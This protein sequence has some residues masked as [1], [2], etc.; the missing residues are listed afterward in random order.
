MKAVFPGIDT[1]CRTRRCAANLFAMALALISA[2]AQPAP[3]RPQ[4]NPPTVIQLAESAKFKD[5]R[6]AVYEGEVAT[7]PHLFTL[8]GLTVLTPV[9]V[10]LASQPGSGLKLKLSKVAEEPL[11]EGEVKSD[12]IVSYTFKTEGGFIAKVSGP[13]KQTPY[14]LAVMVGREAKPKLF[15]PTMSYEDFEKHETKFPI[16]ER[17]K[18]LGSAKPAAALPSA[19]PP[20]A[21]PPPAGQP[22][23]LWA[24]LAVLLVIAA[25]LGFIALRKKT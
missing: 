7:T 10:I 5:M 21:V 11:R 16:G 8:D 12:G 13:G 9:S 22:F 4:S 20:A 25:F 6:V 2:S 15:P 3:S 24:I 17:I 19:S 23:V 1:K 18:A 14:R